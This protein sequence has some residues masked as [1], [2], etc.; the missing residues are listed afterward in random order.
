RRRYLELNYQV[1]QSQS[2]YDQ[3]VSDFVEDVPVINPML[4]NAFSSRFTYHRPGATFRY[5]GEVHNINLGAAY[6]L[7]ELT[8]LVTGADD[9]IRQ[10]YK[11]ILPRAIWRWN[12]GNGKSMRFSYTTRVSP[13][14]I[15][16]LSPVI[17]NSD[18]LR[19]YTG[20]PNLDAEYSHNVNLNFHSFSQFSN[21]SFFTSL[22]TSVTNDRIITSRNIDEQFREVSSP[23]NIDREMRVNGFISYGRPFK[24]IHSR[25]TVDGNLTST[26]SQTVINFNLLDI[27]RWARTAGLS[28]S[29][30]NSDVLEYRLGTSWTF[31]DSYYPDDEN[32]DQHTIRQNYYVDINLTVWKKWV[33]AGNYSYNLYTSDQFAENQALPL[34]EFSLSRFVLPGDKGQLKLSVFDM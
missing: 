5:G 31:T 13:P 3:T 7:S 29:N 23:I 34:M 28:V 27:N 25:V 10:S 21:T 12:I 20:N 18:P 16:Q 17:D 1:Y 14:S 9:E 11:H 19:I 24:V 4:S 26:R 15:T 33:L 6:Q 30:L 32:L 22:G 2:D 8:G